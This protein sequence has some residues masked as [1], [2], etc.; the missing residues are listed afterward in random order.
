MSSVASV[1]FVSFKMARSKQAQKQRKALNK[2]ARKEAKDRLQQAK[3]RHANAG[4]ARLAQTHMPPLFRVLRICELRDAI[5]APE[6]LDHNDGLNLAIAGGRDMFAHVLVI[7]LKRQHTNLLTARE[8][9]FFVSRQH[10]WFI[11]K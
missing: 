6:L 1:R 11:G 4:R 5:C 2:Q 3:E 8:E 10:G 7:F 9:D